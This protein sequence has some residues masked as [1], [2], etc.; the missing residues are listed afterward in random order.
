[1]SAKFI[2]ITCRKLKD[3]NYRCQTNKKITLRILE[4]TQ[5]I[6]EV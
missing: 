6:K 1:M 5:I 4:N 2:E 3:M